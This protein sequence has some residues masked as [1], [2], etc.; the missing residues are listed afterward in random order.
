MQNKRDREERKG[1]IDE[2]RCRRLRALICVQCFLFLTLSLSRSLR[3]SE[4]KEKKKKK[5]QQLVIR[6]QR[7]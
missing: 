5:K 7:G 4:E 6:R 1:K 2:E 3:F